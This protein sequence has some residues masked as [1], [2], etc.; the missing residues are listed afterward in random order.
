MKIVVCVKQTIDTEAVI[1]LDGNNQVITEGQ[2][3]VIDPYSEFAVERAVQIKEAQGGEV[4]TV[5]IGGQ[6]AVPAIRHALSMGADAGYL[7]D[8]AAIAGSDSTAKAK[9][10]AAAIAKLSPDLVL[11]GCKSADTSSAQVLPRTATVLGMPLVNVVTALEVGDASVQATREIDDG[12]EIVEVGLPAVITAQQGLAEPRYPNVR[13][14][15]QSKKKPVETW[16]LADIGIDPAS[17]GS[18]AAKI[19]SA[20]YRVKPQRSGGRIVEGEPA[21]AV[22]ET[23]ALLGSEAKVV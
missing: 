7:I 8:D 14:I 9:I 15:M 23:V 6:E 3:L 18:S 16:T 21:E 12:V 1:E 11:G 2:T 17:V 13:D 10:L 20:T 22:A 19:A 4:V 5:T